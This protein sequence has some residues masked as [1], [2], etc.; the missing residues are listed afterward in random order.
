MPVV[1]FTHRRQGGFDDVDRCEVI[2]FELVT[3]HGQRRLGG[4][5]FFHSS[6]E[7]YT[8]AESV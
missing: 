5:A 7:S 6:Y 3:S 8:V 2:G 4:C 1:F